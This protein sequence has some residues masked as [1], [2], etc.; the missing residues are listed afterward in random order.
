MLETIYKDFRKDL[1]V[2]RLRMIQ[3]Y[4][5]IQLLISMKMADVKHRRLL[6]IEKKKYGAKAFDMNQ[7]VIL[8]VVYDKNLKVYKER[9]I[10]ANNNEII[11]L[12]RKLRMLPKRMTAPILK[13]RH[14][15][16]YT[17]TPKMKKMEA[18]KAY[19]FYVEATRKQTVFIEKEN[20]RT[21]PPTGTPLKNGDN[22]DI[23]DNKLELRISFEL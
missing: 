14:S 5:L 13:E 11:I 17:T 3:L 18:I 15:V 10:V 21:P 12:A 23:D 19:M 22:G 6:R 16:F 7:N 9:L 1:A 8:T 4:A 2:L 20:N